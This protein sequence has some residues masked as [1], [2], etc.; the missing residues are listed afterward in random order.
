MSLMLHRIGLLRPSIGSPAASVPEAF[1]SEDWSIASGDEEA[2]VTIHALPDDGG[3]T[4]TDIEYRLDGGTWISSGGTSGF[5]IPGLTNDQEYDVELRAANS[6]GAGAASDTKTVTPEADDEE[7]FEEAVTSLLGAKLRAFWLYDEPSHLWQDTSGTTA[8]TSDTDLVGRVDDLSGNGKHLLQATSSN[9]PAYRTGPART[10]YD[11]ANDYLWIASGA[12]FPIDEFELFQVIEQVSSGSY[13]GL[14][15]FGPASG[16]DYGSTNGA[17]LNFRI[18]LNFCMEAGGSMFTTYAIDGVAPKALW[19]ARRETSLA[20]LFLN[21]EAVG[22]PDTS[23]TAA[24]SPHGGPFIDGAYCSS[25]TPVN[26]ANIARWCTVMTA[27]LTSGERADL[28]D[29]INARYS[30]W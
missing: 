13:D 20:S 8:V 26:F 23:F 12:A 16:N 10:V 1:G 24:D 4:I 30:L 5:S 3:A 9:R 29:L 11:G 27:P 14:Y 15:S 22:T 2:D 18:N 7:T 28:R 17:V 19:E 21:G 25:S 6:V